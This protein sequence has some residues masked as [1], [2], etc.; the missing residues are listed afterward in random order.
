MA[1]K[2]NI[3]KEFDFDQLKHNLNTSMEED[4]ISVSEELIN[5]TMEKIGQDDTLNSPK[6][7]NKNKR[8]N[9]IYF[10]NLA[11]AA[12]IVFLVGIGLVKG[13]SG[14]YFSISQSDKASEIAEEMDRDMVDEEISNL[15]SEGEFSDSIEEKNES[16]KVISGLVI[17]NIIDLDPDNIETL[18]VSYYEDNAVINKDLTSK[19]DEVFVL[20]DT[21]PLE[22]IAPIEEETWKYKLN[23]LQKNNDVI[24]TITIW[25]NINVIEERWLVENGELSE[26][27]QHVRRSFQIEEVENLKV[28]IEQIINSS[29]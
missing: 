14:D 27:D 11:T 4:D 8:R 1:T 7:S 17:S 3:S 5:R 22:E 13:I 19:L 16:G 29:N 24:Y 12:L 18:E 20:F 26:P 10:N 6:T 28:E 2:N 9:R 15:D 23:I 25:E 21:Y